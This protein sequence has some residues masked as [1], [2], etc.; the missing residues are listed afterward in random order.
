MTPNISIIA[1]LLKVKDMH[2]EKVTTEEEA[3]E[4]NGEKITIEKVVVECRPIK[5]I[6]KQCPICRQTCPGYDTKHP[7]PSTWRG[8]NLNGMIVEVKYLRHR[9][10]C[11][12]HGCLS[13]YVPWQDGNTRFLPDFNNEAAYLAMNASKTTVCEFMNVNW[14]TVG[15]LCRMRRQC[16][17]PDVWNAQQRAGMEY[18][19]V[20]PGLRLH[21][22][23]LRLYSCPEGSQYGSDRSHPSRIR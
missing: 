21:R 23:A 22:S 18:L 2:I 13:E 16:F 7:T 8:P 11:P 9:I 6:Q 3:G 5:R 12:E 17:P 15:H 10:E 19:C 14:R 4:K 1:K 20:V